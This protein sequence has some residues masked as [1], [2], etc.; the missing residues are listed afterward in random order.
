MNI[1]K[2][3]NQEKNSKHNIHACTGYCHIK[4]HTLYNTPTDFIHQMGQK[5]II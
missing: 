2:F 4:F 3:F 5:G 1:L